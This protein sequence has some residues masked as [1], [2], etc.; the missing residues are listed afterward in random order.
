MTIVTVIYTA[1]EETPVNVA[2][3]NA[4]DLVGTAACEYAY[5]WTNNVSGSWSI[6]IKSM[7]LSDGTEFDNGDYNDNVEIL[8]ER[9]NGRGLRSTS[10]G[11]IMIVDGTKYKVGMMGFEE[12]L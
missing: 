4:G 12:V 5:R 11:D 6:K 2:T 1:F 3:V 10:M 7:E 9:P 8:T